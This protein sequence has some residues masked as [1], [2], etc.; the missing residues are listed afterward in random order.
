MVKKGLNF[1]LKTEALTSHKAMCQQLEGLLNQIR[2]D[3]ELPRRTAEEGERIGFRRQG[4]D[5]L[6]LG[7]LT[8]TREVPAHTKSKWVLRTEAPLPAGKNMSGMV[9]SPNTEM[10]VGCRNGGI[11]IYSSEGILQDTVLRSVNVSALD[12]MPDGGYVIR[13]TNNII[14]LYTEL[15]E[16]LDVTFQTMGVT[17]GEYGCESCNFV[18]AS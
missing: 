14:S 17:Q 15:C 7:Q 9:I 11:V 16:K 10:A 12:F 1:P 6:R 2:P 18:F 4:S 8:H 5:G 13:D 3:E